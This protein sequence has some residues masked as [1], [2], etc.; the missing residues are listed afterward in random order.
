MK[1]IF[2][3]LRFFGKREL[4]TSPD[5]VPHVGGCLQRGIY[6]SLFPRG[7]ESL[8]TLVNRGANRTSGAQLRLPKRTLGATSIVYDCWRGEKLQPSADGTLSF[9][10]EVWRIHPC[11]HHGHRRSRERSS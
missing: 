4:L 5:W 8:Y 6:A 10:M 1:R 11:P 2:A 7:G 9:P 3:L